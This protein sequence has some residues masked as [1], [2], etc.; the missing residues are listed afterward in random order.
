MRRS[1]LPRRAAALA[2]ATLALGSLT[3]AALPAALAAPA[4][5]GPAAESRPSPITLDVTATQNG[6]EIDLSGGLADLDV[7]QPTVFRFRGENYLPAADSAAVNGTYVMVADQEKWRV[8]EEIHMTGDGDALVADWIT[9]AQIKKG[10]GSWERTLTVGGDTFKPGRSYVVGAAAAHA[11]VLSE[12]H[13]DRGFSFTV[14]EATHGPGVPAPVAVRAAVDEKR[15]V[16]VEWDYDKSIPGTRF[17]VTLRCVAECGPLNADRPRQVDVSRSAGREYTF[18][19]SDPGVY[20][21]S[22]YA[23]RDGEDGEP[24][25]SPEAHS[26][27]IAVGDVTI[28]EELLTPPAPGTTAAT[29]AP[30]T[31]APTTGPSTGAPSTTTTTTEPTS[32]E[33]AGTEPTSTTPSSIS[34]TPPT[35]GDGETPPPNQEPTPQPPATE[36]PAGETPDETAPTDKKPAGD[37]PANGEK[38]DAPSAAGADG[39]K[40]TGAAAAQA[41]GEKR[42]APAASP[43]P[44]AKPQQPAPAGVATAAAP[45]GLAS[46]GAAALWPALFGATALAAGGLAVVAVR[47]RR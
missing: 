22:V 21:A 11:L 5:G 34:Q 23:A 18:T 30:G 25:F 2:A 3:T 13:F 46:T 7:T 36:G 44:A 42:P 29:S 27:P 26:A 8:G 6:R 24:V 9:P 4:P 40:P 33:T 10:G 16:K 41:Q 28:P 15:N 47:R 19:D 32:A 14:P 12:R 35:G 38:Q 31:A 20:V 45:K 1:S 17:R 43:A 37:E 39:E